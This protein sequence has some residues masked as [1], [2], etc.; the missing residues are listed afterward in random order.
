MAGEKVNIGPPFNATKS[1]PSSWNSTD[2]TVAFGFPEA[3][4]PDF[5][6]DLE[7]LN[8][9]YQGQLSKLGV[10]VKLKT[11]VTPELVKRES[12]DVVLVATGSK[13]IIG[14]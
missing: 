9:W 6:N 11:E 13:S 4:A 7:R 14:P 2:I 5:K 12:P 10:E 8:N 3:S 1:C